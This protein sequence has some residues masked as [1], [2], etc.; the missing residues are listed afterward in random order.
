MHVE[1]TIPQ[2]DTA[3]TS[4]AKEDNRFQDFLDVAIDFAL[5]RPVFTPKELH[6]YL[7]KKFPVSDSP[8]EFWD[9]LTSIRQAML[10]TCALRDLDPQWFVED[11]GYFDGLY[12]LDLARPEQ[13][14]DGL[15]ELQ[16]AEHARHELEVLFRGRP[17]LTER[18]IMFYLKHIQNFNDE[19]AD[20]L[21][22]LVCDDFLVP[23]EDNTYILGTGLQTSSPPTG[24][25]P[26]T[27]EGMTILV[28]TEHAAQL[29]ETGR[30]QPDMPQREV[31]P[32]MSDAPFEIED[33]Q[34]AYH[35][36]NRLTW[37]NALTNGVSVSYLVRFVDDGNTPS[38]HVRT[39]IGRLWR[40]GYLLR[41][42]SNP[43]DSVMRLRPGLTDN[44][45]QW[46][47][48]LASITH[49]LMRPH[50]PKLPKQ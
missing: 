35:I 9:S 17:A 21:I 45:E 46:R 16:L 39:I 13:L 8:D 7:L 24:M 1:F 28:P 4:P 31:S 38:A 33:L 34:R 48:A 40:R 15:D 22:Q 36:L 20:I 26:I 25:V 37:Q 23:A 49:E 19:A 2:A 3:E 14:W 29:E 44:P 5:A 12:G 41:D 6:E 47:A 50:V 11:G 10:E 18:E 43:A 42:T 30:P 27:V 32:P